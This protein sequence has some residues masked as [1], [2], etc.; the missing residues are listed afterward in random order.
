MI[1]QMDHVTINVTDMESTLRFYGQL[2]GFERLPAVDM[3]DHELNYFAVPGGTKLELTTYRFPV[4]D[5]RCQPTDKGL[6]RHLAFEVENA[7]EWEKKL[8]EAGF[9]FHIPVA[10][11]ERLGFV[12][13]LTHDPNG[14]EIELLEY[15]A[16]K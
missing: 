16:D 9:V 8:T 5:C 13:G 11:N 10:F 1:K 3:G 4:E 12:T 6:V 2:L 7:R 14:V 15:S